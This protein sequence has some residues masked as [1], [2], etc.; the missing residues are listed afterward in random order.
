MLTCGKNKYLG[1]VN[2]LFSNSD[3][4]TY[5]ICETFGCVEVFK[6]SNIGKNIRK[7]KRE[8]AAYF[9]VASLCFDWCFQYYICLFFH[10]ILNRAWI[11]LYL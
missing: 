1:K 2:L 6:K 7:N 3:L 9:G 4:H 11:E 8:K 5:K 10:E